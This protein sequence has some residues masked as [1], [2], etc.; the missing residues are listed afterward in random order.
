MAVQIEKWGTMQEAKVF[1]FGMGGS[2]RI[3]NLMAV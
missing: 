2:P 3:V 1:F